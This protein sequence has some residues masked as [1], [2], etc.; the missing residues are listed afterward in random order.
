MGFANEKHEPFAG[1]QDEPSLLTIAD[2]QERFPWLSAGFSTRFGGVGGGA[3]DSLNCALHVGDNPED[4]IANR[5]LLAQRASFSFDAWTCAEQVHGSDVLAVTRELRGAGRESR[6]EAIASKDG[7]ITNEPGVMLAAFYA[8]CVPLWFVDPDHRA[9]GVAHAGWRGTAADVAGKTV[10]AMRLAYGSD[11]A[12]MLAAIG[13]SIQACCY[14]VDD[15]VI[16]R[17][18]EAGG[19]E[20]EHFVS[21]RAPGRYMLDLSKLNA[22]LLAKAG[23]LPKHIEITGYCTSC[24]TDLFFSHRKECGKTGRMT[25]WIGIVSEVTAG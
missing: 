2:W 17:V 8:D 24:R 13:P 18:K 5:K 22:K 4:V 12:R 15:A 9:V 20:G 7:L 6:E 19:E 16:C 1:K 25:A 11:P 14:E 3:W 21:S 10:E 23:I